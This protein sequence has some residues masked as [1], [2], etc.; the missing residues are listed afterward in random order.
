MDRGYLCAVLQF[1]LKSGQYGTP[2]V[3]M[4]VDL[5]DK[6]NEASLELLCALFKHCECHENLPD[7]VSFS[8]HNTS[9]HL[10]VFTCFCVEIHGARC[11]ENDACILF[12]VD[13]RNRKMSVNRKRCM[14]IISVHEV[15]HTF[16]VVLRYC[17]LLSLCLIPVVW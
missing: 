11:T 16:A 8:I 14:G 15:H 10:V 7:A 13:T 2:L 3:K 9:Q 12:S 6:D 17:Q 4:P 1:L 5:T